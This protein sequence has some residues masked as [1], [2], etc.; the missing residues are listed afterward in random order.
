M[1]G[2]IGHAAIFNIAQRFIQQ[3]WTTLSKYK[4]CVN[5]SKPVV[6]YG[7]APSLLDILSYNF[8]QIQWQ[9]ASMHLCV[10]SIMDVET[11]EP[12]THHKKHVVGHKD[13]QMN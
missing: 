10:I 11:P 9:R 1:K 12:P 7:L 4:L 2:S 3:I 8:S 5:N 13:F 6:E